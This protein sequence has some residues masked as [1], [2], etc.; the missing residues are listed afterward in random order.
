M[1]EPTVISARFEDSIMQYPPARP[2]SAEQ[3]FVTWSCPFRAEDADTE[4]A[5]VLIETVRATEPAISTRAKIVVITLSFI[6]VS[7]P[8]PRSFVMIELPPACIS[9]TGGKKGHRL[10]NYFVVGPRPA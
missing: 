4:A 2:V 10:M 6:V 3:F 9:G 5:P 7:F 8:V 1:F